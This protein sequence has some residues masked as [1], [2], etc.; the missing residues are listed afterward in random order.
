MNLYTRNRI[1]MGKQLRSQHSYIKGRSGD[2]VLRVVVSWLEEAL[3][4]KEFYE[5]T[6]LVFEEFFNNVRPETEDL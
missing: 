3:M 5:G 4:C 2:T 1:P 6:F